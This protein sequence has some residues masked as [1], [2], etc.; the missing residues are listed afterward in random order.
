MQDQ[1]QE[2]INGK[3]GSKASLGRFARTQKNYLSSCNG[4][5]KQK[6]SIEEEEQSTGS[7]S[8]DL[9]VTQVKMAPFDAKLEHLFTNYFLT[10]GDQHDIRQVFIQEDA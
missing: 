3:R 2:I 9:P 4:K 5:Q 8:T 6:T 1:A 10:I 7:D